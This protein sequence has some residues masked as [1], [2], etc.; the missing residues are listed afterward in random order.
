MSRI[1]CEEL[2]T[3]LTQPHRQLVD[4]NIAGIKPY[5]LAASPSIT[6]ITFEIIQNET[7]LFSK[8]LSFEQIKASGSTTLNNWHGFI[9]FASDAS[10]FLKAGDYEIKMS[11]IGYTYSNSNFTGWCKDRVCLIGNTYG[12]PITNYTMNPYSYRL[13]EYAPREK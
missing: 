1:A 7:T 8:T 3:T 11:A 10:L 5:L 4:Q 12:T 9:S 13:I 6:S 2:I